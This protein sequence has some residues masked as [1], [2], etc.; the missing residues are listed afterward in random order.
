MLVGQGG[1]IG[2][3]VG[4][5]G[6][7]IVDTQYARLSEKIQAAAAGEMVIRL[8]NDETTIIPGHGPLE[9]KADLEEWIGILK[10]NRGRFQSLIDQGMS[11]DQVVAAGV[12]SEWDA[13]MGG[14]FMNPENF[15][16]LAYQSLTQ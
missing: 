12:T 16:R 7:M 8:A 10:T 13:S 11:A 9:D 5:D 3:S 15:T 14:G 1:N 6:V 4:A 2:L